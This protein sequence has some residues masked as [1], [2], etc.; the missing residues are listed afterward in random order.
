MIWLAVGMLM[1]FMNADF[2][3][4]DLLKYSELT[5]HLTELAILISIISAGLKINRVMSWRKWKDTWLLLCVTMPITI[6]LMTVISMYLLQ[7]PLAVGL[8]LA[9]LIAPTDPVLASDVQVGP[10][11]SETEHDVR[12]ALTSEAGLNDG[13]A[14]PFVHLALIVAAANISNYS[15]IQWIQ[16][17]LLWKISSGIII[18]SLIG[19]VTAK[20][21]LKPLRQMK[22]KDGFIIIALCFLAYGA[23]QLVFGNGFVGVFVAAHVFRHYEHNHHFHRT[24]YDFAEQFERL[25]IPILLL[26]MSIV[27]YQGLFNHLTWC[28]FFLALI[29][30]LFIRPLSAFIGLVKSKT[31]YYNQLVIGIFGVRGIG[32]FYYLAYALNHSQYFNSYGLQLWR[33]TILIVLMSV[34]LHGMSASLVF[35]TLSTTKKMKRRL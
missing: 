1:C 20:V 15:Y 32:S 30:L 27:I 10:P 6:L 11:G 16:F 3:S 2:P 4:I 28:E 34:V 7:L 33:I 13:L 26:L 18:G 9:A 17:D 14:S 5:E 12:F 25:I 22:M 21:I 23:T 29:F 35:K 19:Y 24:L 8:L 31:N